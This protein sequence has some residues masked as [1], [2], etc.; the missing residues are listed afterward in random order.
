MV[1]PTVCAVKPPRGGLMHEGRRVSLPRGRRPFACSGHS[2][3]DLAL[4]KLLLRVKSCTLQ[5]L[6][7]LIASGACDY[8]SRSCSRPKASRPAISLN[9][10]VA[11]SVSRLPIDTR[12][13]VAV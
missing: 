12:A 1:G 8:G 7:V 4:C 2:M 13:F 3:Q 6:A 5:A 10:A 9:R 11:G